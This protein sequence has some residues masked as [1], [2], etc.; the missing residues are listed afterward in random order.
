M[1]TASRWDR[2][3]YM[4]AI[5]VCRYQVHVHCDV[6]CGA[7]VTIEATGTDAT[8]D[9]AD[10]AR[11][12]TEAAARR[13]WSVEGGRHTCPACQLAAL[14]RGTA[15]E[16]KPVIADNGEHLLIAPEPVR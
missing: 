10:R 5:E 11:L 14:A 8:E 15:P 16:A 7:E 1:N 6:G 4:P 9:Q 13:M 12:A 2:P 3:E